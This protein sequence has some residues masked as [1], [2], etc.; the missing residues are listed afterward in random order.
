MD[1]VSNVKHENN[2]Q[3]ITSF[4]IKPN[5]VLDLI[6]SNYI[7]IK[8]SNDESLI[9]EMLFKINNINIFIKYFVD[10]LISEGQSVNY[11][12]CGFKDLLKPVIFPQTK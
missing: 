6:L 11:G 12:W 5:I 4:K 2:E 8:F 3:I 9:I 10:L 7:Y 1:F